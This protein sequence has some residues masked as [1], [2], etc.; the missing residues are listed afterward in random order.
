MARLRMARDPFWGMDGHG[1]KRDRR[2]ERVVGTTALILAIAASGLVVAAWLRE[3][4]PIFG[5]VALS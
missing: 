2:R 5:T 3:L 4:A 1:V